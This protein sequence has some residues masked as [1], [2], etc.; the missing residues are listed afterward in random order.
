MIRPVP[1]IAN[2]LTLVEEP[3]EL[4]LR[5]ETANMRVDV[6][7][8]LSFEALLQLQHGAA[9]GRQPDGSLENAFHAARYTARSLKTRERPVHQAT[10]EGRFGQAKERAE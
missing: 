9:L 2:A 6:I 8:A 10:R 3:A 1:V 4:P 5:A 7:K